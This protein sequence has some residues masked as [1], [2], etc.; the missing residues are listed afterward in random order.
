MTTS[1]AGSDEIFI[2]IFIN[3]YISVK[4]SVD[5]ALTHWPLGDF[6]KILEK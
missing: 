5:V 4:S 6:N 3:I 1:A 2:K